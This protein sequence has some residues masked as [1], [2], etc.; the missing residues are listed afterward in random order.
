M[1][2][3]GFSSQVA[4][5]VNAGVRNFSLYAIGM[6]TATIIVGATAPPTD[7]LMTPEAAF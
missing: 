2:T 1:K 3:Q 7:A 6:T 5:W 4:P